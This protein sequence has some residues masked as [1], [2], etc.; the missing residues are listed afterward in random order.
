MRDGL[1]EKQIASTAYNVRPLL[2][3][4]PVCPTTLD[5]KHGCLV[6]KDTLQIINNENVELEEF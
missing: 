1:V 6:T 2:Q 4:L 5:L 3:L